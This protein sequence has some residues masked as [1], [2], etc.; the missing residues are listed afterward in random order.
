MHLPITPSLSCSLPLL[1][2]PSHSFSRSFSRAPPPAAA[3]APPPTCS[4]C[5]RSSETQARQDRTGKRTDGRLNSLARPPGLAW[6]GCI[7]SD[8]A[9]DAPLG[10]APVLAPAPSPL[11]RRPPTAPRASLVPPAAPGRPSDGDPNCPNHPNCRQKGDQASILAARDPLSCRRGARGLPQ[12]RSGPLRRAQI[13]LQCRTEGPI[14]ASSSNLGSTCASAYTKVIPLAG[15][16]GYKLHLALFTAVS[17][18]A[19]LHGKLLAKNPAYEY[20][21]IDPSILVS[22]L[23][24]L[25][26]AFRAVHDLL[27]PAVGL[28]TPNVHSETVFSLS[29]SHNITDSYRRFGISPSTTSLLAIKIL[30]TTSPSYNEADVVSALSSLVEGTE[31]PFTTASLRSLT[32][33]AKVKKYYKLKDLGAVD[34]LYA[35]K[36]REVE[37][38]GEEA[39]WADLEVAVL[40]QMA[41]RSLAEHRHHHQV[42]SG[43]QVHYHQDPGAGAAVFFQRCGDQAPPA[44][45]QGPEAGT[46]RWVVAVPIAPDGPS[47]D[48]HEGVGEEEVAVVV[49]LPERDVPGVESRLALDLLGLRYRLVLRWDLDHQALHHLVRCLV[50]LHSLRDLD[51]PARRLVRSVHRLDC[52][53]RHLA[54]RIVDGQDH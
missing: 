43:A 14:R 2:S 29:P 35:R 41:L 40:G 28:R 49:V 54:R 31:I 48:E 47:D 52:L 10:L 27:D 46:D 37:K 12:P 30:D 16:P 7:A 45:E 18:A 9:L 36:G 53:A 32:D 24:P 33:V 6:P 19:A 3:A 1:L 15:V 23:Q 20:A 42:P 51:R 13:D 38:R 26:A 11:L 34:A 5:S 39:V 44:A 22:T 21:F 50:L 25:A 4:R 17:N 8:P